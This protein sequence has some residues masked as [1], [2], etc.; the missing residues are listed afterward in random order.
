LVR[1]WVVPA[2]TTFRLVALE[3][4]DAAK[5][6]RK[7]R[8]AGATDSTVSKCYTVIRSALADA[9]RAKLIV[10]DPFRLVPEPEYEAE[11]VEPYSID[12]IRAFLAAARGT[13]FAHLF[14][15]ALFTQIREGELLALR[16]AQVNLDEGFVIVTAGLQDQGT[17]ERGTTGSMRVTRSRAK[18][19]TRAGRRRVDLPAIVVAALRAQMATTEGPLV[20]PTERGTPLSRQNLLQ[21]Y[22]YPIMD[23][24]VCGHA[25]HSK[26]E[27]KPRKP[28]RDGVC[29][30][31]GCAEY[32]AHLRHVTFHALRHSGNTLLAERVPIVVLQ[33]RLGH[34]SSKTT[35]DTYGHHSPTMQHEAVA[36]IDQL[37]PA[38][39]A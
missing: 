17:G 30:A 21:R 39:S 18:P 23:W 32:K 7:L 27:A 29:K 34:A 28:A 33:Q 4:R 38:E 15:T 19:K 6:F 26:R 14:T 3:D 31:C 22:L 20:F 12:E 2:T 8:A 11:E 13:R 37:F 36:Y 35:S 25:D 24:C 16:R 10:A 9:E 1:K 5:I